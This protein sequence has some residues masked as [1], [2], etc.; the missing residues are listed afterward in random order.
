[1]NRSNEVDEIA[2]ELALLAWQDQ[3]LEPVQDRIIALGGK[4]LRH[5]QGGELVSAVVWRSSVFP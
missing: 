2:L 5:A 4:A 1:M 3:V